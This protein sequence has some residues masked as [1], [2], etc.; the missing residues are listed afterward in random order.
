MVKVKPTRCAALL[1]ALVSSVACASKPGPDISEIR[2]VKEVRRV[3]DCDYL[4]VVEGS[5]GLTKFTNATLVRNAAR[6]E[7]LEMAA[8]QAA[9]HVRWL[10]ESVDWASMHVTAQAFDCRGRKTAPPQV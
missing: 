10:H 1:A 3:I 6:R 7:A 4:G 2:V 8:A 9:T 5:A